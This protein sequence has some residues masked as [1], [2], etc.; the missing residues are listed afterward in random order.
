ME[1]QVENGEAILFDFPQS[2]EYQEQDDLMAYQENNL[3]NEDYNVDRIQ[4]LN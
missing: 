2:K 3:F 1:S 4:D